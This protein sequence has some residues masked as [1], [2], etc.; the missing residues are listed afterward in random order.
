MPTCTTGLVLTGD[1]ATQSLVVDSH[2]AAVSAGSITAATSG[3]Y[4]TSLTT[5]T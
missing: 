3:S 5:L 4:T 2:D 1:T